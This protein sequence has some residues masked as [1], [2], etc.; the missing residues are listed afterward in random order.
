MC[1]TNIYFSDVFY[2]NIYFLDVYV[3]YLHFTCD[4]CKCIFSL[5]MF[6][7]NAY[8]RM[9]FMQI[10]IFQMSYVQVYLSTENAR[11]VKTEEQE[12]L[13]SN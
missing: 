5:D 6:H 4:L 7:T 3:K 12:V 11:M 8:L 13:K 1:Y 9:C 10:R 2:A